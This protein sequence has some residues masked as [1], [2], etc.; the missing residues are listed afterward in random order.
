MYGPVPGTRML[1]EH[2]LPNAA[3]RDSCLM[4]SVS[5]A[6]FPACGRARLVQDGFLSRSWRQG[7]HGIGMHRQR[8]FVPCNASAIGAWRYHRWFM[9]H[10]RP[11]VSD[12]DAGVVL[13]LRPASIWHPISARRLLATRGGLMLAT[14][15]CF[16]S[17][18][19]QG[20]PLS[21]EAS[22]LN[23]STPNAGSTPSPA[24]RLHAW[25]SST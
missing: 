8:C 6:G 18:N 2:G 16:T 13:G 17:S 4:P 14:F 9:E 3:W 25:G 23:P 24:I 19:R 22:T 10:L 11:T 12:D 1:V 5:H 20:N 15:R 7:I 21:A